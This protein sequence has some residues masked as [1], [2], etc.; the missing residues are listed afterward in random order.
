MAT[1]RGA[2]KKR[3][4]RLV[5]D[6]HAPRLAYVDRRK[7]RE[8]PQ[9]LGEVRLRDPL[10]RLKLRDRR[11]DQLTP[12]PIDEPG[13]RQYFVVALQVRKQSIEEVL[14][15]QS[16]R[17]GR[18]GSR[19]AGTGGRPDTQEGCRSQVGLHPNQ[20][21]SLSAVLDTMGLFDTMGPHMAALITGVPSQS[22]DVAV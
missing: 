2:H 3:W 13:L 17:R 12:M 22:A 18:H 9:Q 6:P 1:V 5:G 21:Q 19:W 11:V 15:D 7:A 8:P 16:P 4:N 20:R 14:A 10:S